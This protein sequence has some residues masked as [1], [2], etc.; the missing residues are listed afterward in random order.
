MSTATDN[1]D[2]FAAESD[3]RESS[4][5][6]GAEL[7]SAMRDDVAARYREDWMRELASI[8]DVSRVRMPRG[9]IALYLGHYPPGVFVAVSGK[10]RLLPISRRDANREVN[11]ITA[12]F[13]FPSAG[14]LPWPSEVTVVVAEDVQLI[15][16]PRTLVTVSDRV[17]AMLDA[18]PV[19]VHSSIN[20]SGIFGD[21]RQAAS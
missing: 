10:L 5:S 2:G 7:A 1:F 3:T 4:I 11:E 13:V 14:D 20:G 21:R 16:I 8:P 19:P 15:F 9:Q 12:P 17:R 6:R 18:A